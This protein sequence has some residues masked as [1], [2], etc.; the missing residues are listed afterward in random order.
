MAWLQFSALC[1]KDG[2]DCDLV[3][4]SL[5]LRGSFSTWLPG[6]PC[7][8]SAT[9]S[10]KPALTVRTVAQYLYLQTG[11]A[12]LWNYR[13]LCSF[14]TML[15]KPSVQ[16]N[17]TQDQQRINDCLPA[18][19]LGYDMSTFIRRYGRYLNEKAFAYRQMAFDFTRVKKGYDTH[20]G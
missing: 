20:V 16:I 15:R 14:F 18:L 4:F 1:L 19:C 17:L 6:P 5:S 8:T 13:H 2:Y 12:A 3:S 11:A 10:T 7:S 9:L